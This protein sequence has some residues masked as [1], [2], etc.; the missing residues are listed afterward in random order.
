MIEN[1]FLA[2]LVAG[3]PISALCLA[4]VAVRR[5]AVVELFTAGQGEAAVSSEATT[6]AVIAGSIA[7]G[8]ALGLLAA[9]VRGFLPSE[10][11][12]VAL[13]FGLAT[14]MTVAALAMRTPMAVEKSVLNY[15]VAG[16][17]GLLLPR[18]LPA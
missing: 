13:A 16:S 10:T 11:S 14:V 12:Y 1:R 7:I 8:P 9:G 5:D 2:G 3:I 18:L 4:Y 6:L 15:A 17:L